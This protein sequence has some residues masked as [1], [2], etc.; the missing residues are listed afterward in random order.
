MT[1]PFDIDEMSHHNPFLSPS[2]DVARAEKMLIRM[3]LVVELTDRTTRVLFIWKV[4]DELREYLAENLE[5]L[6]AVD[7][8][9]PEQA[10]EEEYLKYAPEADLIV[11]WRPSEELLQRAANL[12]LFI[13]P[14]AGVQHLIEQFRGINRKQEVILVNGHG[15]AYFTAQHTVALLLALTNKVIPHHNWMVEGRW[16]RGDDYAKT[17]PLRWRKIGLLGYGAVNRNVHRFLSGF[18][19]EFHI[20]RTGW[21][22]EDEYPTEIEQYT[23]GELHD[24]LQCIDTLI[25]AV[26]LTKRTEGLI[27]TNELTLLGSQGLLVNMSRGTVV[28]EKALFLALKDKRIAGAAI[29]VWYEYS[30]EPDVD[31]RRYPYHYP[32][33]EL[34]N[35][36][37]SPHRGASPMDDLHRWNEVIE[38]IKRFANGRTDYLNRVDIQR[39][40]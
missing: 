10:S 12:R 30:P 16:R 13:N 26:P 32:F 31:A 18:D 1:S 3:E 35:V 7:L 17:I 28:D 14:G 6:P 21:P 2:C 25:I 29:D 4:R 39:E 24:F 20:L 8:I 22:T 40:Y 5:S 36:V 34:E 19:N 9:F 15:N 27:G 11:G 33:H 23:S 37:L 38:N